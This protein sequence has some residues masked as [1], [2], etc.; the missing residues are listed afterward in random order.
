MACAWLLWALGTLALSHESGDTKSLLENPLDWGSEKVTTRRS[1]G[2]SMLAHNLFTVSKHKKAKTNTSTTVASSLVYLVLYRNI[3]QYKA[4][5]QTSE[6]QYTSI[7]HA[8]Q[9]NWKYFVC[10]NLH[11]APSYPQLDD[12]SITTSNYH[13]LFLIIKSPCRIND[14]PKLKCCTC[15]RTKSSSS[16]AKRISAWPMPS[17][18]SWLPKSP[19]WPLIWWSFTI[20]LPYWMMNILLIGWDWYRF[21]INLP[22]LWSRLCLVFFFAFLM[23]GRIPSMSTVQMVLDSMPL[24]LAYNCTVLSQSYICSKFS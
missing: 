12:F 20:I 18:A 5:L 11:S 19:P 13:S 1:P 15:H 22:I 6:L 10:I 21:A 24:I 8:P 2:G 7:L 16:W 14:F 17:V 9:L 4:L 23:S 3:I